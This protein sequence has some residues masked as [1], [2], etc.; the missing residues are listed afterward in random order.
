MSFEQI[1]GRRMPI[2]VLLAVPD[3][4]Q[5]VRLRRQL[6]PYR[7]LVHVASDASEITESLRRFRPDVIVLDAAIAAADHTT[8]FTGLSRRSPNNAIPVIML[9]GEEMPSGWVV[10][11]QGNAVVPRGSCGA[12]IYRT[13]VACLATASCAA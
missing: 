5:A 1:N 6:E 13:I 11:L 7:C 3:I 12:L 2:S 10:R 9:A 4:E 8:V